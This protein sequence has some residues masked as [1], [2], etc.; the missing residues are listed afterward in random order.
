[1][2]PVRKYSRII[3]AVED[4]L[5][6]INA[7]KA[8]PKTIKEFNRLKYRDAKEYSSRDIVRLRRQ[9][10]GLSQASF[11]FALNAKLSTVQKWERGVR[12]PAP[13][14]NRLFQLF[15]ERGLSLIER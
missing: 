8:I 1:M 10:L 11:A 14:A 13:Y 6:D 3:D 4:G 12:K 2:K 9:M 5:S 15:E 7:V